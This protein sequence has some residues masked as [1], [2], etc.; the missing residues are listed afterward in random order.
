M[1]G[2]LNIKT[3]GKGH[4]DEINTGFQL[5]P[6]PE[7][8]EGRLIDSGML[9]YE[10]SVAGYNERYRRGETSHTIHVWWARRPHSAMRTLVFASLC[11]DTS[12]EAIDNMAKLAVLNDDIALEDAKNM[13]AESYDE[14][15]RLLD[16]FGGGGTIPFESKK[17]G[18]NTYSIDAN[19]LSVFIQKCNMEYTENLKAKETISQVRE[20]GERVLNRLKKETNWLYPLREKHGEKTFGYLWSYSKECD[21]CGYEFYLIKRPWLSR[22]KGE[23]RRVL[24]Y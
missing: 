16:M 7:S 20:S 5:A 10:A 11:K 2:E 3:N 19:E 1:R 15:P 22:K 24:R 4:K 23:K 18:V 9:Q 17:L 21:E 12:E 14:A 13:L 6:I 8:I